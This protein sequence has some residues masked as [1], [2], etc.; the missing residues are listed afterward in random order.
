M[1]DQLDVLLR[2]LANATRRQILSMVWQGQVSAGVIAESID[3]A[4]ASVSEHL[5]VLRKAG[6]V[7]VQKS[8]TSWNYQANHA[9]IKQLIAL[10]KKEFPKSKNT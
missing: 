2:A 5:K 4:P 1:G 7:N 3:L 6:L 8:G 9:A 10:L